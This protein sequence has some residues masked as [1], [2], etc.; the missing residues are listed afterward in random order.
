MSKSSV[1]VKPLLGG[2]PV[3]AGAL[4]AGLADL[5][6][7]GEPA[8]V[9]PF[10]LSQALLGLLGGGPVPARALLAGL[11]DLVVVSEPTIAHLVDL[12]QALLV[13]LSLLEG[14]PAPAEALPAGLADLVVI[15]EPAV[16]NPSTSTRPSWSFFP[17]TPSRPLITLGLVTKPS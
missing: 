7:V 16:G 14:S 4:L 10:D 1:T 17:T 12:N 15:R 3:P 6:V 9:Y 5:V 13:L 8:V 2:G 11:A